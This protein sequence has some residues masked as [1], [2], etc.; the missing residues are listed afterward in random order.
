MAFSSNYDDCKTILHDVF[1][2]EELKIQLEYSASI[3]QM[4][5]EICTG[6]SSEFDKCFLR[7]KEGVNAV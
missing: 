7:V 1:E 2:A 6:T 3:K 5:E 4:I